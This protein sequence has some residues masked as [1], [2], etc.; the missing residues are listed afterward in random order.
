MYS[1]PENSHVNINLTLLPISRA[2]NNSFKVL[3][4]RDCS[5][6]FWLELTHLKAFRWCR[7][8]LI[9]DPLQHSGFSSRSSNFLYRTYKP[10]SIISS[11]TINFKYID[12]FKHINSASWKALMIYLDEFLMWLLIWMYGFDFWTYRNCIRIRTP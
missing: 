12:Q 7:Q 2:K 10:F 1:Y 6:I 3:W 5:S 8:H 11:M 4:W 9:C